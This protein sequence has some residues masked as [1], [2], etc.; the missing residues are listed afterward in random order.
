MSRSQ[1]VEI[2]QT[3]DNDVLKTNEPIL[4]KIGTSGLPARV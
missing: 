4:T 1:E 2:G 3:S